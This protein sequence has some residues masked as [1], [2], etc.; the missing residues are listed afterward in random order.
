METGLEWVNGDRSL[1]VIN[2][3][4]NFYCRALGQRSWNQW[5]TTLPHDIGSVVMC[6]RCRF[7]AYLRPYIRLSLFV[8]FVKFLWGFSFV[9]HV[10]AMVRALDSRSRGCRFES[11]PFRFHVTSCSHT[12][13]SVTKQYNLVLAKGRWCSAAGN[14]TAGLVESNGNLPLGLWLVTC[15][16]TA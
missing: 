15:G 7:F 6:T 1:S 8:Y 13:A 10:G 16:L 4:A 3:N 2:I 12:C 5:V 9:C 14:V 11:R